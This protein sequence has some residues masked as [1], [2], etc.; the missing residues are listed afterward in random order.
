MDIILYNFAKRQNST[1]EPNPVDATRTMVHDVQIKNE[2]SFLSPTFI[3]SPEALGSGFS[4]TKFNYCSVPYWQ[5]HYFVKDWRWNPPYWELDLT[6]DALA[7]FKYSIADTEAYILRSASMFNG[8][9]QDNFYPAMSDVRITKTP[10]ACPWYA[11][12]P[13]GGSYVIGC[14]NYQTS[15]RVGAVSYYALTQSQMG[16]ILNYLFRDGIYND[17]AVDEIS[18]GL[19]KAMFN[20]FQYIT[21]C[22]WFPFDISAFGSQTSDIKVGYWSTHVNGIMVSALAERTFITAQIPNH[23][24]ISR[25]AYLNRAPYTRVTLYIP[26]FGSIPIDTNI[27]SLGNY[28]YSAVMIDHVT[29]QATIRISGCSSPAALD[30]TNIMTE[31]S[32]EIGVPIQLAQVLTDNF[33]A[34]TSGAGAIGSL[35]TG[36]L[37]GAI[38][39][40]SSA[41]ESQMPKVSTSGANGSFIAFIQEPVLITEHYLITA[42]NNA[43]NGRPLC[44]IRRIGSLSGYIQCSDADH[45]FG[46]TDVERQIINNYLKSGFYYE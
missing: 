24:Q 27:F 37:A 8:N 2:T 30:H 19:F 15:N 31:R 28:L 22:T 14:I 17:M 6:V 7:S 41:I 44:E 11:V 42:E 16:Q 45:S 43:E 9:V 25:G 4:P 35:V 33:H 20:P 36:N 39:G 18:D 26:P 12:S 46:C 40:I 34:L 13:S 23:P 29:G 5:R 32:G 3:L 10:V 38:S 1:K 21:S